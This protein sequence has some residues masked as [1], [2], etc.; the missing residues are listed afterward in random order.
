MTSIP[1]QLN[2]RIDGDT[3]PRTLRDIDSSALDASNFTK[4]WQHSKYVIRPVPRCD[5]EDVACNC[6]DYKLFHP[7]SLQV[8]PATQC[9][10][11][12]HPLKQQCWF[13][14]VLWVPLSCMVPRNIRNSP[15]SH[16]SGSIHM[17]L[18]PG[19][20]KI[21]DRGTRLH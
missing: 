18:G 8:T 6:H 2:S 13:R 15:V 9:C 20:E 5:V 4:G 21:Y 10:T 1:E 12:I 17:V 3:Q 16:Q 14:L 19:Q 7:K 11:W